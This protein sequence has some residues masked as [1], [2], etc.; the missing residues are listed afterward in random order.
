[1]QRAEDGS[2]DR[3][4]A[5]PKKSTTKIWIGE[6]QATIGRRGRVQ[7][8]AE[9]KRQD[10]KDAELP[11]E[12]ECGST[13]VDAITSISSNLTISIQTFEL[14]LKQ[15]ARTTP[16]HYTPCTPCSKSGPLDSHPLPSCSEIIET[17]LLLKSCAPD[18]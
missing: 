10:D 11:S 2:A 3:L 4:N 16:H 7:K 14:T 17:L 13:N 9:T 12:W 6:H 18:R 15:E 1:M 5:G 8:H